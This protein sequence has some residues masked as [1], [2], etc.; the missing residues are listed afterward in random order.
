AEIEPLIGFFVN[1]LVM[2]TQVQAEEDFRGLLKRVREV[3]LGGYAH[4]DVPFE[5][6][7]EELNPERS[8]S[9]SPLFQVAFDMDYSR[10]QSQEEISGLTMSGTGREFKA[11]RFDITLGMMESGGIV[12]GSFEY[13]T[14]LFDDATIVRMIGHFQQLLQSIV[15]H[16][17]MQ[18]SRLPLLSE[19]ETAQQLIAWNETAVTYPHHLT[20]HQLFETQ[21]AATPAAVA[22][23]SEAEQI[24]YGDLNERA[25]HLAHYLRELGVGPEQLIGVCCER[26]IEM[27]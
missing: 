7:V 5:K 6:L 18:I 4:Q 10:D 16:P 13:S 21:A 8:L 19:E 20:L 3:C 15:A 22:L 2:R 1:A 14:D 24:G 11:A 26:S 27:M 25:N 23:I 12:R 9:Y 17:D